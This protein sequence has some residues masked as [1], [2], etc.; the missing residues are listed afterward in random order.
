MRYVRDNVDEDEDVFDEEDWQPPAQVARITYSSLEEGEIDDNVQ[1]ETCETRESNS[2]LDHYQILAVK[3][4]DS[5]KNRLYTI[6]VQVGHV[7]REAMTDSGSPI[8]FLTFDQANMIVQMGKGLLRPL[9]SVPLG[10]KYTEFNGNEL[11]RA[12]TL[13]TSFRCGSWYLPMTDFNV[14]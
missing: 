9:P 14:L 13:T 2:S 7:K 1:A 11:K 12:S 10:P 4:A 3:Q 5:T 8:S 6:D